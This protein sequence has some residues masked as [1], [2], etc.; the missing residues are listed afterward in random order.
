MSTHVISRVRVRPE[1]GAYAL[2]QLASGAYGLHQFLWK[3]YPDKT[4]FLFRE[5]LE[6][7]GE[8]LVVSDQKAVADQLLFAVEQKEYEPR[9]PVGT[10]LEFV[11]RACATVYRDGKRHDIVQDVR[12]KGDQRSR[13]EIANEVGPAWLSRQGERTGF[14][15]LHTAVD[16]Y[17]TVQTSRAGSERSIR[18]STLDFS[19]VLKVTDSSQFSKTLHAGIGRAKAFGAGLMLVRR[20]A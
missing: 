10:K 7:V 14:Q 8:Y 17:R 19:G 6:H 1:A 3:L 18:F 16:S 9:L 20:L 11:L 5:T 4:R 13:L 2:R 12:R 15:L